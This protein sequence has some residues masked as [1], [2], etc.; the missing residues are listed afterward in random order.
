M[1]AK[2]T[3]PEYAK[4]LTYVPRKLLVKFRTYCAANELQQSTVVEELLTRW[5]NEQEQERKV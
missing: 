2:S 4:F 1:S 3:N 5:V